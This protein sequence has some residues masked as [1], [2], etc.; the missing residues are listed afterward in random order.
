MGITVETNQATQLHTP[1][2][3]PTPAPSAH[4]R[5]VASAYRRA[6]RNIRRHWA[7]DATRLA[8]LIGADLAT[9]V[10][11]RELVRGVRE[12]FLGPAAA[13]LVSTLF[14]EG[15]LAGYQFA[16]ALVLSLFIAGAYGAGDRRRDTG[17]VLSGVALAALIVLYQFAWQRPLALVAVQFAATVVVVGSAFVLVRTLVDMLVR[18]IRLHRPASRAVLVVHDGADASEVAR[19]MGGIHEMAV[20]DTI[21]LGARSNGD[22]SRELAELA[23]V[24]GRERADTVLVWTDLTTQEFTWA[25]DVALASGCR[26]LAA[27]RTPQ[28]AGIQPRSVWIEGRPLLELTAPSL[29]GWQLAAKRTIDVLGATLGL[30][31]LSPVFVFLGVWIWLD[32]PGPMFFGQ[33]RLGRRGRPFRCLKFRSMHHDAE[34]ILTSD[35][36]LHAA[37]VENHFKLPAESDPRITRSGRFLRRTSLDE[38]PQLINVLLGQMSLVG[39]RPIVPDEIEHYGGG[40]PLFLSLKPGITGAWAVRGRSNVGYPDRARVELE[41]I[42][43]WSVSSDLMILMQT[44]PAVMLRRGAH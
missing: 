23:A 7:R 21:Q 9:Y 32:S 11:L 12:G 35:P 2:P 6:H 39:P 16:V 18:R 22:L 3:P 17:R 19:V 10:G 31:V 13:D 25:V 24:I 36:A 20:V 30:V 14:G 26:L 27:P 33:T 8:V 5:N 1:E 40:A 37:Y 4:P 29:Q 15:F 41:Y 43:G 44:L 38:L 34:A 28:T 42:R